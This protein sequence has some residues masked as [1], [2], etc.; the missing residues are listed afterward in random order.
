MMIY[1]R[2]RINHNK[3]KKRKYGVVFD[4]SKKKITIAILLIIGEVIEKTFKINH[5]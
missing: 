1:R 4:I 2:I 5:E 3:K